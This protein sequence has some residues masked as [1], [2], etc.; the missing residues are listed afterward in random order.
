MKIGIYIFT[1]DLR[2]QDNICLTTAIKENDIVYPIFILTPEQVKTNPY[3]NKRAIN[4]MCQ[5]LKELYKSIPITFFEGKTIMILEKILKDK[6][7]NINKIY[8]NGDVSP[9]AMKREADIEKLCR[10][11]SISFHKGN[12]VFFCRHALL[13]RENGKPYLKFT[14]FYNNAKPYIKKESIISS[15][16]LTKV[17]YIKKNTDVILTKYIFNDKESV[18]TPG[19]KA[20]ISALNIFSKK[21]NHYARDRD[22]PSKQGNSRLAAYLHFGVLS[23]NEVADATQNAEFIRQLI[24]REFYLYINKYTHLDYSKSSYTMP[25]RDKLKWKVS[26]INFKKWCEGNTGCPIVD[27]GMRELNKTG[28]MHNRLRMIVAMYLIFYLQIDWQLGEKYFAQ[29][30]CDYDYSNNLG[31]WMWCASWESWGNDYFRVFAMPSQM[32]R[33][34]KNAEY[35]KKWIPELTDIPAQYLYDWSANYKKYPS[36]NYTKPIIQDLGLIRKDGISLY[37]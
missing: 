8:I 2:I 16:S 20:G 32:K 37:K 18:Y 26:P 30:L 28:H 12:D 9:F 13:L 17:E 24:W 4:F 29:N 34:D 31:G 1:R 5:S 25:K 23:P 3:M 33:Y 19:R 21:V 36:I 22:F 6:K 15:P 14:P 10:H 11:Y 7:L 27:A 35:V